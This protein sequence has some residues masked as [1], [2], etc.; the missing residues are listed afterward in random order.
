MKSNR[1]GYKS[2][3]RNLQ[4]LASLFL[5]L[6]STQTLLAAVLQ[7]V[8]YA[9]LPGNRVEI[10]L[11]MSE[12]T[13]PSREFTTNNP[14][15]ISL[16]FDNTSSA[17][18]KRNT[19]IDTGNVVGVTAVEAGS[20]TRVVVALLEMSAYQAYSEGNDFVITIGSGGSTSIYN[21]P[22]TSSGSSTEKTMSGGISSVD[23]RRGTG[24]EGQII[25]S[26]PDSNVSV[27]L[28]QEGRKVIA[29][30]YD[31]SIQEALLR[32]LDVIDFGTPATYIQ[33]SRFSDKVRVTIDTISEFEYLAY[34]TDNQFTIE[35]KP[36]TEAEAEKIRDDK[37]LYVGE[38]LSL[39]F[40]DIEVRA[41][42]Q[43]IAQHTGLNLVAS[44]TVRG[45]LTLRLQNV[46]WDQ[47]LDIILKTKGLDKRIDGNVMLVAP[48][49][50]IAAREK[51]ELEASKQVSELAPSRTEL[52]QVNYAMASEI[53]T[54][55]KAKENT[56]LSTRGSVTV[57][58]RTN[59]LLVHDTADKLEEIRDL[60]NKLDVPVRQV[61]IE[62]R[63]VTASSGWTEE[64][65]VQWGMT[66]IQSEA[67]LSGSLAASND[68]NSQI[69]DGDAN[70]GDTLNV[71]LPV[72]NAAGS[73][74]ISYANL[75]DGLL[76]DLE[77]SALENENRGEV[78]AS[79]RVITANQKE[80]MI[81]AGEEIPFQNATS[82]GATSV[83]FKKAVLSL[84]VTPQ[85]TPDDRIILDL[86]VTQDTR[87]EDTISGPAINTQQVTTQVLVD[88][89]QTVV[90]GGIYQQRTNRD[91][92][93]VPLLGDIPWLGWLFRTQSDVKAKQELLIFV[94]PKIL[95]DNMN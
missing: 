20:K 21:E 23:F 50:E 85:I 1:T 66:K 92:T 10:R 22:T 53:A 80:A 90:L 89:G 56:L 74:G 45:N 63:I 38:R 17:L 79:P 4:L 28:R 76:L 14:A 87:G 78:I 41:V 94:T 48:A 2:L 69:G 6:A 40:Q 8:S 31:A 91:E 82:S 33:T 46:P 54:L 5:V 26:L 60:T 36:L 68:L 65:G 12:E 71:S 55:L 57:D 95:K 70:L 13:M 72:A 93:K 3:S 88:N 61:Q 64:L 81:E 59:S 51:M 35:L 24:G 75:S 15:R 32:K 9:V 37:N 86:T 7:D 30:F 18:A 34:Q 84:T 62:S 25:L 29:D 67:T 43:I 39:M 11:A 77:L 42:L 83:Q 16:D 58:D 47:A 44:D 52:I 73:F 49:Q 19:R 27:D